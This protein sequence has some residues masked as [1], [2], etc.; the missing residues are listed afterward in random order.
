MAITGTASHYIALKAAVVRVT[1]TSSL[2][3]CHKHL[4][5]Y[6]TLA[7]LLSL[8]A[9]S[10]CDLQAMEPFF[11]VIMSAIFLGD[12]P[13][14]PVLLTLVPIVGG[15]IM[16]SL[17]EATFNW[18]G[19]LAAM[20]SNITFQSRNVLSKKFMISKV[21]WRP[22]C[23]GT[24]TGVSCTAATL[25]TPLLISHQ[26]PTPAAGL[27]EQASIMVLSQPDAIALHMLI[28]AVLFWYVRRRRIFV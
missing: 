13:P 25:G 3:A 15:V 27:Y 19:F 10:V 12:V 5:L 20:F 4:M 9:T 6:Q 11:S 23:P 2:T 17:S 7:A 16:A 26:S 28:A 8:S 21:C 24:C 22:A 14:V 18:T 1:V